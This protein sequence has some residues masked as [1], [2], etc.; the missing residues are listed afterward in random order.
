M[1]DPNDYYSRATMDP[2]LRILHKKAFIALL[3]THYVISEGQSEL[4]TKQAVPQSTAQTHGE[5]LE[6]Q[7]P[8]QQAATQYIITT[9]TNGSGTSEVH[10]TKP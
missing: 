3:Q 10:I 1:S 7:P 2:F 9:T 8:N 4:E 6:Q 5:D